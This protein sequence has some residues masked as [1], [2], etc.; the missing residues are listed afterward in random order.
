MAAQAPGSILNYTLGGIQFY[1]DEGADTSGGAVA[2]YATSGAYL[3]NVTV[4]SFTVDI[5]ELDHFSSKSGNRLKDRTVAQET[6]ISM[7][8][9]L[10]EPCLENMA[11]FML[12]KADYTDAAGAAVTAIGTDPGG[13]ANCVRPI[14]R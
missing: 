10:D 12:G 9:T 2:D 4:G 14:H 7:T 6:D 1:F 3:G 11:T 5:T 8:L 13:N